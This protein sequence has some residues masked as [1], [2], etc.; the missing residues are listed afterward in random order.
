MREWEVY[1]ILNAIREIGP[2]LAA[3]I[4]E[5]LGQDFSSLFELD[6]RD[7][8]GVKG[9]GPATIHS[10]RNWSEQF[11]LEREK[12]RMERYGVDF[13]HQLDPR[14]PEILRRLPDPPLGFYWR[15]SSIQTTPSVAVVG[16]RQSSSYG[17]KVA[18]HL[19]AELVHNGF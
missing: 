19:S 9:V 2:V 11:D 10:I 16:T 3:R 14:Y 15:G 5:K 13:I 7:L 8:Q 4:R 1:L 12:E 18:R 6:E 17:D